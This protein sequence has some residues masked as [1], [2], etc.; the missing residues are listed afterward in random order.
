MKEN[1]DLIE[2]KKNIYLSKHDP[3]FLK[4]YVK[5]RPNDAEKRFQYALQLDSLGKNKESFAQLEKAAM[6][7][8]FG[9]KKRLA[10]ENTNPVQPPSPNIQKGSR[11]AILSLFLLSLSLLLLSGLISYTLFFSEQ[12][13]HFF[14]SL[15]S[16]HHYDSKEETIIHGD[17][18]NKLPNDHNLSNKELSLMV[19]KTALIGYQ[20]EEGKSPSSLYQLTK[21]APNNRLSMIP[22]GFHYSKT[23]DGYEIKNKHYVK[24]NS[25]HIPSLELHFYPDVNQLSL[26]DSNGETIAVFPVASGQK[27]LPFTKSSVS[28]RVENPNGG[29]GPL[30]TR[31][32]VL[33]DNYAIHGTN[34]PSSIG[35]YT[36]AGCLRLTNDSIETLFPYIPTGTRFVV[37]TGEPPPPLLKNGLPPMALEKGSKAPIETY[38]NETF[39]WKK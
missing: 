38:P 18:D 12:E 28:L 19:I 22:K 7:G 37:K 24:E 8:H 6:L 34:D 32:L 27:P 20:K 15:T 17:A 30:G 9:A 26:S 21:N 11:L 1:E 13:D 31:G 36:T 5:Y 35:N 4:K 3:E 2:I 23:F 33:H 39:S 10:T 14:Q 29:K 16:Y 25:T